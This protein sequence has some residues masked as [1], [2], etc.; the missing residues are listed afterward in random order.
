[1]NL[2]ALI[3]DKIHKIF[4]K[5]SQ[6]KAE[7]EGVNFDSILKKIYQMCLYTVI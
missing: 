5:K 7:E 4:S 2:F 6:S 1:M 3:F